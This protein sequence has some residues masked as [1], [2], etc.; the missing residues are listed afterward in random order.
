MNTNHISEPQELNFIGKEA[1]EE[2]YRIQEEKVKLLNRIENLMIR[3]S[4]Y[5]LIPKISKCEIQELTSICKWKIEF[6]VKL[7]YK[8][9]ANQIRINFRKFIDPKS[10]KILITIVF[11]DTLTTIH[12]ESF[13]KAL[14]FLLGKWGKFK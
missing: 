14:E 2:A 1:F 11:A 13:D 6:M 12:F 10:N 5:E 4:Q 9:Y 7:S 3:L 8:S